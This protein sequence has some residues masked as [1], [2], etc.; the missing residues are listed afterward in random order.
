MKIRI[1][2]TF[3]GKCDICGNKTTVF[4][5]GDEDSRKVLTICR[6]CCEKLGKMQ[7]GEAV[8]EFGHRDETPFKKGVRIE[9]SFGS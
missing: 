7:A 5:L 8:E 4:T 1:S 6:E 9:K 2:A 3:E